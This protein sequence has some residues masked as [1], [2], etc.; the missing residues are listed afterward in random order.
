MSTTYQAL[1][2]ES[3]N[4]PLVLKALPTPSTPTP[5]GTAL[6]QPLYS[7]LASYTRSL[8]N[9]TYTRP[10][11]YPLVPGHSCVGRIESVGADATRL[12]PG[13]IVWVDSLVT[14]RDDPDTQFL[15]GFFGGA[16]PAAQKLMADAWPQGCFAEKVAVPLENCFVLPKRW[17]EAKAKGGAGYSVKDMAALSFILV[18]FAGLVD[19]GV[20]AGTT[21]IV[22]PATGKFSGG[23]VL[24]A[25]A[26]GAKVVAASRSQEKLE[27]LRQFPGARE[28]LSTVRLGGDVDEDAKKLLE[29]TG[30]KGAHVFMDVSPQLTFLPS[31]FPAALKALRRNAQVILE[32]GLNADVSF[33]YL[34]AMVRNLTVK[35]KFMYEREHVDKCIEMIDNGNLVLGE[36]VGLTVSG[37]YG[38]D[39]VVDAVES[40]EGNEW[41]GSDVLVAPNGQA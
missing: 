1:V 31:H 39:E 33:N 30:N 25:L 9:G 3:A 19:A 14:A 26:L 18:G 40:K 11:C 23:A 21:V 6:V 17:F 13:D 15:L 36:S 27:V 12:K 22:A 37:V 16:G 38:L 4:E 41:W 28:R 20:G 2:Q 32:G 5:F 34:D 10:V 29:A 24:A 8:A 7:N 35:G